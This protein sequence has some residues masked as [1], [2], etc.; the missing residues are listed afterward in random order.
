[1]LTNW[2]SC[3]KDCPN[4]QNYSPCNCSAGTSA[5]PSISCNQVPIDTVKSIFSKITKP[6]NSLINFDFRLPSTTNDTVI[7]DDIMGANNYAGTIFIRCPNVNYKL[8]VLS[9]AFRSSKNFTS[10]VTISSCDLVLLDL[11]F[12]S[13]FDHLAAFS[14][15]SSNNIQITFQ[16]LPYPLKSLNTLDF[17]ASQGL[18]ETTDFPPVLANGLKE[19]NLGSCSI[20][21]NAASRIL[22][23]I[24]KSSNETLTTLYLDFN[25]LSVIP[26]QISWLP[27]IS[28]IELSFNQISIIRSGE[29][30]FISPVNT[31]YVRANKVST[32]EYNSFQ[33]IFL[34]EH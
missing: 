19:V 16:S 6:V 9:N 23:W 15:P 34:V 8:Q 5:S 11:S 18:N 31:V 24:L 3:Q 28:Y 7:P 1:M 14:L 30:H 33:G 21:N 12:L 26:P 29:F 22:N 10:S 27:K 25:S 2:V 17:Y 4:Q 32:V 13:H 20:G